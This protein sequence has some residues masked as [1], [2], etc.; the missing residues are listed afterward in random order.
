MIF[1]V[2]GPDREFPKSIS[3]VIYKLSG[4]GAVNSSYIAR[5]LENINLTEELKA[6]L[7]RLAVGKI[8]FTVRCGAW[9]D[10]RGAKK[11]I[12][13]LG[14][15]KIKLA[16]KWAQLVGEYYGSFSY[17]FLVSLYP[18][19]INGEYWDGKKFSRYER[20]EYARLRLRE[21]GIPGYKLTDT[22]VQ[23]L[24][25]VRELLLLMH[26]NNAVISGQP[27]FEGILELAEPSIVK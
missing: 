25:N 2:I 3:D 27:S 19:L 23:C 22:Y 9:N 21:T 11:L 20:M 12:K 16:D 7:A 17:H 15:E 5:E 4:D 6:E 8:V 13:L 26:Q 10:L 24:W 14:I 1:L 18:N